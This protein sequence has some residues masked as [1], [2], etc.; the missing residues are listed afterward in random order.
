MVPR[1]IH[2]IWIQGA[3]SLPARYVKYCGTW[4]SKNPEWRYILWDDGSLTQLMERHHPQLL[5][6]YR[7]YADL[8]ARSDIG[9]YALLEALGGVYADVDTECVRP[10]DELFCTRT[11]SL[12]IQVYKH[13]FRHLHGDECYKHVA[14]SIIGCTPHHPIW[15]E[16]HSHLL[17]A[18]EPGSEWILATGP[19]MFSACVRRYDLSAPGDVELVSLERIFTAFYLPRCYMRWRARTHRAIDILDYND[20]AR[21]A[22]NDFLRSLKRFGGKQ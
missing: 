12:Y 1:I 3:A 5:Y 18:V 17:Q 8:A 20:S 9:R 15:R 4:R 13:L 6:R 22:S 2:Q 19:P 14:N 11:A 16:V 7:E 10:I 21:R